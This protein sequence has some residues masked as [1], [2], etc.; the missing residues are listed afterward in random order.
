MYFETFFLGFGKISIYVHVFMQFFSESEYRKQIELSVA[1]WLRIIKWRVGII[2]T[3]LN[4]KNVV[5]TG[6]KTYASKSVLIL[7]SGAYFNFFKN[8]NTEVYIKVFL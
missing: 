4:H 8:Q 2:C 5:K 1:R 6:F 7:Y 3:Q